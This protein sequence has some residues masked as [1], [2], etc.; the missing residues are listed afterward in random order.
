MIISGEARRLCSP[1]RA[2]LSKTLRELHTTA[3]FQS[4]VRSMLR[5]LYSMSKV[6]ELLQG[7]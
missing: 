6:L 5:S 3:N 2:H 7:A 4:L 1:H